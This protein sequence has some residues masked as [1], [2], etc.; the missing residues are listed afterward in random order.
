MFLAVVIG[1]FSSHAAADGGVVVMV[2]LLIFARVYAKP[3]LENYFPSYKLQ[4]GQHVFQHVP[5]RRFFPPF[6]FHCFARSLAL[7][8]FLAL[9]P[10]HE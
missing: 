10:S 2:L 8:R 9:S 4:H 1:F 3:K 6:K 5:S 7:F